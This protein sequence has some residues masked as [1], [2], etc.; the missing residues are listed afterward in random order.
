MTPTSLPDVSAG[1]S[2]PPSPKVIA[3]QVDTCG[4]PPLTQIAAG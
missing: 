1:T 3:T 4:I 2:C